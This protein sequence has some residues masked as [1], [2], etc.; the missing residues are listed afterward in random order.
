MSKVNLWSE[1]SRGFKGIL[2][3]LAWSAGFCFKVSPILYSLKFIYQLAAVLLPVA[4]AYFSSQIIGE[5]VNLISINSGEI[6]PILIQWIILTIVA[7]A[8]RGINNHFGTYLT[9]RFNYLYNLKAFG[10]YLQRIVDLDAQYHE[11]PSFKTLQG[12]AYDVLSWRVMAIANR[13][14]GLISS[15]ISLGLISYIFFQ[16][17]PLFL[18]LIIVPVLLNF[19]I[20]NKYGKE[21]Y[22]IWE[23]GGED[24]KHINN[25]FSAFNDKSVIHEAKIYGFGKYIVKIFTDFTKKFMRKNIREANIRYSFLSFAKLGEVA[26]FGFIQYWLIKQVLAKAISVQGYSFYLQNVYLVAENLNSIQTDIVELIEFSRYVENLRIFFS[27]PEKI[28]KPIKIPQ[29]FPKIEFRNVSFKYP[30]SRNMVLENVSFVINPGEHVALVGENGAGKTTI[31]K[32]LAR[33]YDVTSGEILINDVNIKKIDLES[34]YK[35]WGILFQEFAKYWLSVRENIGLGSVEDIKD[36]K[37]VKQAAKKAGADKM[38]DK[39]P[40][41]YENPLST[42]MKRGTDLSGGQWQKIGIARGL[43]SDPQ[44]IVLDEPTSALDALAEDE[45]FEEIA[46]ISSDTT[47]IIV[48][49]RFSTV[50]NTDKIL[51]LKSGKISEQGTHQKLMKNEKLYYKMFT[52][53]AKGYK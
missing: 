19:Y 23:Y 6:T 36:K 53:Q 9:V 20:N 46:K 28:K 18:V 44:L 10:G 30:G 25:A 16:I 12:R 37:L 49:H 1:N 26:G 35:L 33:F 34:Y 39:L 51:V 43:F 24:A 42:N 22:Y 17:N 45:V 3:T 21:T 2:R 15:L 47:M 52:S 48:S 50:R 13:L 31:I 11:N 32:L 5:L 14:Q 27:L 29:E 41:K 40:M 4:I 7:T 38:I 8:L